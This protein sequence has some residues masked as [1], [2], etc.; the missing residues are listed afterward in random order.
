MNEPTVSHDPPKTAIPVLVPKENIEVN[1][2]KAMVGKVHNPPERVKAI[3]E[4]DVLKSII[5][6]CACG[7]VMSIDCEYDPAS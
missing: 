5:V 7:Q 1:V 6:K 2:Q 4:G 3:Y